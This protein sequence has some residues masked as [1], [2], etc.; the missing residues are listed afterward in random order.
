MSKGRF[1]I[2]VLASLAWMTAGGLLATRASATT[3][4]VPTVLSLKL[5]GVVDP[6]MAS[7]VERGIDMANRDGDAAVLLTIDT[8][9]GLDSSMRH[10]VQAIL[11]SKVPVLCYTGPSGARAASAGTFIMLACPVDAMAPGTNIGAAHPVA[12]GG[13]VDKESMRKIENDSAAPSPNGS[14]DSTP[15]QVAR[16]IAAQNDTLM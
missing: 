7:Y 8:P 13:S 2:L 5:N 10:I 11:G 6:F 4:P 15:A 12:L 14:A 16:Q 3:A 9:G 1:P